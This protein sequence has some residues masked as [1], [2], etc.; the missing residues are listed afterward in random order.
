M[1]VVTV[2]QIDVGI[3]TETRIR[4]RTDPIRKIRTENWTEI[5]K[6]PN[7]IR[8]QPVRISVPDWL[9]PIPEPITWSTWIYI[10]L[11]LNLHL[12]FPFIFQ[13][14]PSSMYMFS[15]YLNSFYD[16][17]HV[18]IT[19]LCDFDLCLITSRIC[20]L[21][22]LCSLHMQEL[23][24]SWLSRFDFSLILMFLWFWFMNGWIFLLF[25]I[26]DNTNRNY[27]KKKSTD[28]CYST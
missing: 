1:L 19:I 4:I 27:T 16:W 20:D 28:L 14:S 23:K 22:S 24:H 13:S 5:K 6:N 25:S 18:W 7:G 12:P 9:Y 8:I 26:Q 10:L 11:T 17:L 21:F 2:S 15:T 3:L